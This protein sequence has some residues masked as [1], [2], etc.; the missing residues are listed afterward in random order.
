M[1]LKQR[2]N[3]R[4]TDIQKKLWQEDSLKVSRQAISAFWSKY[5]NTGELK[6]SYGGGR[7]PSLN[8]EQLNFLDAAITANTE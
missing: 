5:Q 4:N 7:K 8:V 1:N 3:L 6:S 2:Y